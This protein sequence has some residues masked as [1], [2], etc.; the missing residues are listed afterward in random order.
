[1]C[2]SADEADLCDDVE[3]REAV[4]SLLD[5][6]QHKQL[7]DLHS[8]TANAERHG[9]SLRRYHIIYMSLCSHPHV[10]LVDQGFLQ[11]GRIACNAECCISH[12][13]S[14]CP[15]VRHTLVLYQDE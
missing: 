6:I 10:I 14:V 7:S 4:L 5:M 3:M 9:S 8:G 2:V 15:S 11:C 12:G 1:M 13:N